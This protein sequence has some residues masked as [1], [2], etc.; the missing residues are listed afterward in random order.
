SAVQDSFLL[1]PR[2]STRCW[3]AVPGRI[4][5][6]GSSCRRAW[7]AASGTARPD[8]P[9]V[10]SVPVRANSSR[11]EIGSII[12]KAPFGRLFL[13]SL[14]RVVHTRY[15]RPPGPIPLAR[16]GKGARRRSHKHNLNPLPPQLV[17][18]VLGLLPPASFS[19]DAFPI[20]PGPADA[21]S[22]SIPL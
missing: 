19:A 21:T 7:A 1:N 8:P 16:K 4:A 13:G 11:R 5:A 9:R 17:E 6:S 22:D 18:F 15:T 10:C 12:A 14:Q 3:Q 20:S 2:T